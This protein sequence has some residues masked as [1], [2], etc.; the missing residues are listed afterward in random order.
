MFKGVYFNH[1]VANATPVTI[2]LFTE[3]LQL[4]FIGG[5]MPAKKLHWLFTEITMELVDRNFIRITGTGTDAGTLEV[6][7]PVFVKDFL[8][9]Y[10]HIR[11]AGL[12]E[13]ALRGGLKASLLILLAIAGIILA[14]HF[15][16]LPWCADRVVDRLPLS[17]DKELGDMAR[18]SMDE[19]VDTAASQLLTRFAAQMK[20]DA[21]DTLTFTVAP[22]KIENAY[23]LPGGYIVVYTAL[24]KRL[25]TK[26]ELAALL[27]HEVAHITCRHSVHKLCRDMSTS[28]VWTAAFGNSGAATGA[29]FS[30]AGALYS[31]TYSR[32]YEE[33]ADIKGLATMRSNHVNQ[34]GMLQLMQ[35]L[36]KLD[37]K[38]KIPEFVSSHP[39]TDN[40]IRYVRREI[41][42][43]PAPVNDH[44]EMEKIFR[45][46]EQLYHK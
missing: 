31:L 38:L 17:F 11:G 12:H 34:Q 3:S 10:K 13:L 42:A 16:V 2:Q 44:A 20:W 6:S 1:Q 26:E 5:A 21:P 45:Q 43:N 7:D 36:Q 15:W 25:K 14:A 9:N 24:L 29:L 30:N 18:A 28:L 41:A 37:H 22:S 46:L 23:A 39:L 8:Q 32:Q 35:E 4:D 19:P 27:S 40:R 33:Q